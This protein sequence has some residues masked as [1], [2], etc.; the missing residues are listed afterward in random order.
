MNK[1]LKSLFV[2]VLGALVIFF[3]NN[4]RHTSG[5]NTVNVY[6]WYGIIPQ[7]V[8]QDFEKETGIRVIYDFYDNNDTLEAKI[9]ATNSGYDIVFPSFIPYAAR[10]SHM[11]IYMEIDHKKIPNLKRINPTII[12]KMHNVGGDLKYIIPFFW[13]TV[14]MAINKDIVYKAIPNVS[15]YSY[16]IL[17]DPS[18]LKALSK[19]GVSFPEEFIDIFPQVMLY[20]GENPKEKSIKNLEI[21]RSQFKK[22]R[23]YITK[24]SSS[25]IINDLLSGNICAGIGTSD[26]IYRALCTSEKNSKKIRYIIPKEGGVLWMDCICITKSAPHPENAHKFINY[27]LRP[28]VCNKITESSGILVTVD[29]TIKKFRNLNKSMP[30]FCPTD[31]DISNFLIGNPSTNASDLAFDRLATRVWS[32]VRLNKFEGDLQ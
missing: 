9:L 1:T 24:F 22:L 3:I 25:T 16:D 2:F 21:F 32:Q 31:E 26:N 27:L 17:F 20:M 12:E 19:H 10:Q 4:A 28:D 11:D 8:F 6:G 23:Q 13:G 18:K 5:V 14:G 29:E 15:V 30:E 7:S